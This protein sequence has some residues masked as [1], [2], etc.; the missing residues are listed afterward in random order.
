MSFD[1]W[2]FPLDGSCSFGF[3]SI[4]C[5]ISFCRCLPSSVLRGGQ[6]QS[7]ESLNRDWWSCCWFK[8]LC[9][10]EGSG[11]QLYRIMSYAASSSKRLSWPLRAECRIVL[12]SPSVSLL[13]YYK[14]LKVVLA[15]L[16]NGRDDNRAIYKPKSCMG[17]PPIDGYSCPVK[18]SFTLASD[19]IWQCCLEGRPPWCSQ[20][21][22]QPLQALRV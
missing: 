15:G 14:G 22:A 21:S 16:V 18:F 10:P 4:S 6:C 7:Q 8:S 17:C 3:S 11:S 13:L 1:A 12:D 2:C 20:T 19:L 9:A 5:Q